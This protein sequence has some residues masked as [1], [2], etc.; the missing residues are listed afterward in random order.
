MEGRYG[1]ES[2][3]GT[4][5]VLHDNTSMKE[6]SCMRAMR[7]MPCATKKPE[8]TAGN[9]K[10]AKAAVARASLPAAMAAIARSSRQGVITRGGRAT[11]ATRIVVAPDGA[12]IVASG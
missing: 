12:L 4:E 6:A 2:R 10:S 7:A 8:F 11:V 3:R 1:E 9:S 5:G